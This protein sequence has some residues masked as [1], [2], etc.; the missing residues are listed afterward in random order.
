MNDDLT[1]MLQNEFPNNLN[2]SK[3]LTCLF[4]LNIVDKILSFKNYIPSTPNFVI[5]K[6][7]YFDQLIYF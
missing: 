7:P 1:S 6:L 3:A 4:R 5:E 2:D